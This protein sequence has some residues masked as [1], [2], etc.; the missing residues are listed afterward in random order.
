MNRSD[1][2]D[3]VRDMWSTRPARRR[4]DR[5]IAGVAAALGRRYGIDPILVR[6]LL[7]VTTVFG[8]VGILLYLLGW[9][10]L[11]E[12]GDSASGAEALLGHG[13]SSMS[14]PMTIVLMVALIPAA[15]G[16]FTGSISTLLSLGGWAAGLFLLHK[17]RAGLAT[18]YA[19]A[20]PV[21]PVAPAATFTG[22]VTMT[23][24]PAGHYTAPT[25]SGHLGGTTPVQDTVPPG[26]QDDGR[27]RTTPP[28]WDPLGVAPF[29]WDLPEPTPVE[30][31]PPPPA[32]RRHRSAVTAVTLAL[33]LMAGGIASMVAMTSDTVGA[34]E[35][36]AL[37]L[38]VVGL[39]LVAGSF[40]RGGRGLIG[41][42]I[43]LGLLTYAS[44]V[45]PVQSIGLHGT[46]DRAWS[47]R[48]VAEV[49]DVY[50]L[51]AGNAS[52]D[53]RDLA[54]TDSDRV[55]T[56]VE[57][58]AGEVNVL[59]PADADVEVRCEGGVGEVD[60]LGSVS[61]GIH[62]IVERTDEGAD[63]EGGGTIVLTVSVGTG[64]VEVN[65]V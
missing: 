62:P 45:L 10:L 13:Q 3:T 7:V 63:G 57:L 52:L 39:G 19:T 2:D 32:E 27:T 6:V 53:L 9:L 21:P 59:L 30:P 56:A 47:A 65:R 24:Q 50:R 25:T 35:V 51:G 61:N 48:T 33:A 17:H 36:L 23:G 8:G 12:E 22:P 20:V 28:A 46:G 58:T 42:A 60:C 5:K 43:P 40:V 1:I 26:V 14:R 64:R 4:H 55:V 11:P 18:G 38:A 37:T 31:P 49:Q 44:A 29:A 54:L 16:V 41:V 34:R 15:A